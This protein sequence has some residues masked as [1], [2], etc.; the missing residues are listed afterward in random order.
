MTFRPRSHLVAAELARHVGHLVEAV[1]H[2]DAVIT[3]VLL[4]LQFER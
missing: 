2:L 3:T 4:I 1:E